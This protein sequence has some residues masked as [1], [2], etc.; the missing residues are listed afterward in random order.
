MADTNPMDRAQR[1]PSAPAPADEDTKVELGVLAFLL[2]EHPARLTILEVSLALNAGP[3]D[4]ESEDAVE[5]A[6]RELVGAGLLHCRDGFV[7]PT[8]AALYFWRLE[9]R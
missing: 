3:A 6:I 1:D 9:M 8:R 5:R 4:F 7:A 2:D